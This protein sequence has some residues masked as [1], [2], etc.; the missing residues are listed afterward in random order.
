MRRASGGQHAESGILCRDFIWLS[1]DLHR[2]LGSTL[3]I[4]PDSIGQTNLDQGNQSV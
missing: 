4:E 2:I 1:R 3:P